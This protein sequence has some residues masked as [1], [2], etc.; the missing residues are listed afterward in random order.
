MHS[1]PARQR[2][3]AKV[4]RRDQIKRRRAV[5]LTVLVTL[6]VLAV[7]AAY[8]IPGQ[9]PAR[10][11]QSA[12]MPAADGSPT[13]AGDVV[14]AQV[15]GLDIVL[16]VARAVTTAVAY[17]PVDNAGTVPF[18]PAGDRLSGGSLGQKLADI[19]AGAA[20]VQYYLM[21]GA[22]GERSSS[23]AGLDVGAVPGSAV[24]SPVDGKVTAIK[25]YR[26]LGRYPDVE[27]HIQLAHDPSLL[28]VL[29]HLARPT[30]AIGDVVARGETVLGSVRGFPATLHQ[31]LSR[32][33]SDTGD[34]VQMMVLR[35]T[36]D[37][38]GL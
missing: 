19:F 1:S 14:V 27:V 18:A 21:D 37:L 9:T 23:T 7:W 8:A 29:T 34:H 35:V 10:V 13:G 32:F 33:T 15:E 26:I 22:G 12:A 6:I 20:A 17:H 5:A 24:V 25:Q 3:R 16:P 30:I 38:A 36:P 4:R 2:R 31:A 28:L 11:P